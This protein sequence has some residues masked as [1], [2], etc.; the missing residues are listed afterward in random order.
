MSPHVAIQLIQFASTNSNC[1]E[2]NPFKWTTEVHMLLEFY[3]NRWR[4]R[5]CYRLVLLAHI[6]MVQLICTALRGDR[7][8]AA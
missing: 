5:F 8:R 2:L 3:R 7:Q 1:K 4:A 6:W